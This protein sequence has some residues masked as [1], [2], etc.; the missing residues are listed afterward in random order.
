MTINQLLEEELIVEK[1]LSV[2]NKK[3]KKREEND[4]KPKEVILSPEEKRKLRA[5]KH[6]DWQDD[7]GIKFKPGRER[8][9][10]AIRN[11]CKKKG[12]S[13]ST[14]E[15]R[16]Y[17]YQ[18]FVQWD[19]HEHDAKWIMT[20][21]NIVKERFGFDPRKYAHAPKGATVGL[22]GKGQP[23]YRGRAYFFTALI[24]GMANHFL[25][26]KD[27]Y[28]PIRAARKEHKKAVKERKQKER[29]NEL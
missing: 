25:T 22:T 7:G 9:V 23:E 21:E 28:K 3:K 8:L 19:H 10:A 4:K 17:V 13:V 5:H 24:N 18:K 15:V 12:K 27:K 20:L 26:K 6:P 29:S 2:I 16:D 1:N 11:L 14:G